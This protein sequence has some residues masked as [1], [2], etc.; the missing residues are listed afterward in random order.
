[1]SGALG[2]R[3]VRG[4]C[5]TRWRAVL[6]PVLAVA[7]LGHAGCSERGS[8]TGQ[9]AEPEKRAE[10][11]AP[12]GE[13]SGE[14]PSVDVPTEDQRA[15]LPGPSEE[16]GPAD[17]V[18]IQLG[19]MEANDE[20]FP[21]AGIATAFKFASPSNREQTGPLKRF[22]LMIKGPAYRPMVEFDRV[23]YGPLE[24]QGETRA[25]QMVALYRDGEPEPAVY[26]FILG[27]QQEEPVTGFWMTESVMRLSPETWKK[28]KGEGD[29]AMRGRDFR[30]FIRPRRTAH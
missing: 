26:G 9:T 4:G 2:V 19:A 28:R 1:M 24:K 3:K 23:E 7:V 16:M 29:V 30:T 25:R 27:K 8:T 6:Y 13:S 11:Q 12:E 14:P 20:P 10:R 22:I 21:N 15:R 5:G 18:K 17:V